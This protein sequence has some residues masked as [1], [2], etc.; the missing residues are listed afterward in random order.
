[1]SPAGMESRPFHNLPRIQQ[2]ECSG[3]SLDADT[4]VSSMILYDSSET[5][6]A[7][8]NTL[9]GECMTQA[10]FSSC[11][12]HKADTRRTRLRTLAMDLEEGESRTYGCEVTSLR[13]GERAKIITWS[14]TVRAVRK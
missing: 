13:S 8:V 10:S 5:I 6:I 12:L 2:V 3:T 11:L 7:S 14:L 4:T 1:M 9:T